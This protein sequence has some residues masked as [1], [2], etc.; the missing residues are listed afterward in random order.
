MDAAAD[1]ERD[2]FYAELYEVSTAPFI[3]AATTA[4]ETR[5]FRQLTGLESSARVLDLGCGWGRHLAA[6]RADGFQAIGL[7]RSAKLATKAATSGPVVRGDLRA[8]P[9]RDGAFDGVACFYASLFF[10]DEAENQQALGEVARV[11][12]PGGAFFMQSANPMHLRRLGKTTDTHR[13]PDGS[14]VVEE[15]EFDR[16][17]GR[18]TGH[19]RLTRP[20][21]TVLEGRYAVRHYAPGELEVLARRAGLRLDRVCGDVALSAFARSSRELIVLMRKPA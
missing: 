2:S 6:L 1:L 4:A 14:T 21:G 8:V 18:D 17:T 5:C 15:T 9:F 12:R 11:L 20:D 19:R 13:L 3:S 10:F 16:E 7:E